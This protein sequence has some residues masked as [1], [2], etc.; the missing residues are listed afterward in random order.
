MRAGLAAG[1]ALAS[2]TFALISMASIV[3][4]AA[5]QTAPKVGQRVTITGCPFAGVTA[6]CLMLKGS[7][8]TIYNITGVTPKPRVMDRMIRLRG[9][10]TDKASMC[11]QAIVLERIR[12]S[13]TRQKCAN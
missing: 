4:P 1:A 7:D 2:I 12:W 9:T 10:V 5:A 8:G 13:R 3:A 6:S 11:N